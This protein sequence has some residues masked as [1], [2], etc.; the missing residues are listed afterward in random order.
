MYADFGLTLVHEKLVEKHGLVLSIETLRKW[1]REDRLWQTRRQRRKRAQQPRH[2]RACVGEL[3]QIWAEP[4]SAHD[5][6]RPLLAHESLDQTFTLQEQR[7]VSSN[8]T[9]HY[10]R[11]MHLLEPSELAEGARGKH[12]QV[13]ENGAVRIFLGKSNSLPGSFPRTTA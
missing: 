11:E 5:A 4:Q 9:L 1:M 8:L 3:V 6:H 7:K 13:R 10:N 12:V 2:G